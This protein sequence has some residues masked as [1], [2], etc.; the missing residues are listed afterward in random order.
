MQL[1]IND[2]NLQMSDIEV[3]NSKVRVILLDEE[4][5]VL[6]ANYGGVYLFPGGSIEDGETVEKALIR[7]LWEEIGV[8]YEEQE[9]EFLV[10]LDIWERNHQKEMV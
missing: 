1:V 2:E 9:L 4:E 7:E 5:N 3:I 10:Q 6:L 8:L